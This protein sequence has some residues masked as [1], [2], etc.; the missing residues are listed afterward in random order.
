M[1]SKNRHSVYLRKNRDS[2]LIDYINKM[3][4]RH[5][6]S[7]ILRSLMRDG[8]KYRE[9]KHDN[10]V[11]IYDTYTRQE[12]VKRDVNPLSLDDIKLGKIEMSE[13]ELR[14]RFDGL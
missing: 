1:L 13:E 4:E 2:D 7:E 3:L 12:D 5:S 11:R 10:T 14:N 6:F 8:I 9:V